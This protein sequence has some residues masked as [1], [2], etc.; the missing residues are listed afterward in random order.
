MEFYN[1]IIMDK[2]IKLIMKKVLKTSNMASGLCGPRLHI[3]IH[4]GIDTGIDRWRHEHH[5][6]GTLYFHLQFFTKLCGCN[7]QVACIDLCNG[8]TSY[9]W[10]AITWTNDDPI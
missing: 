9:R 4:H 3:G 2:D 6:V 8:L 7:W 10:Q 5:T 1:N